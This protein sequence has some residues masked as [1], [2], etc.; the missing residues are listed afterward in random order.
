MPRESSRIAVET[1]FSFCREL[2][3]SLFEYCPGWKAHGARVGVEVYEVLP[4]PLSP[5]LDLPNA[6]TNDSVGGSVSGSVT[7]VGWKQLMIDGALRQPRSLVCPFDEI[8]QGLLPGIDASIADDPEEPYYSP[9]PSVELVL[10]R[11]DLQS[12]LFLEELE[13]RFLV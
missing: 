12:A 13:E 11:P 1:P 6:L 3:Q 10:F 8:P 5:V 7:L 4:V 9:H 2:S